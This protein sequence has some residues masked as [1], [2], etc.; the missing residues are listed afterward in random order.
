[1][2]FYLLAFVTTAFLVLEIVKSGNSSPQSKPDHQSEFTT[3]FTWKLECSSFSVPG[4]ARNA[5]LWCTSQ[6]FYCDVDGE[7]RY[8]YARGQEFDERCVSMCQCRR[9]VVPG[10]DPLFDTE[11]PV[12]RI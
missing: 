10:V 3:T 8:K 5:A 6:R 2:F 12:R 4:R 11:R 1:M 7:T 9:N